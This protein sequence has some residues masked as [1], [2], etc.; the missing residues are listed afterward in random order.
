MVWFKDSFSVCPP[1]FPSLNPSLPSIFPSTKTCGL[2]ALYSPSF[3][4]TILLLA[5]YQY[6]NQGPERL[7]K[8][9]TV[10]VWEGAWPGSAWSRSTHSFHHT[11]PRTG[12]PK[13]TCLFSPGIPG[14]CPMGAWSYIISAEVE[15]RLQEERGQSSLETRRQQK[16]QRCRSGLL[17]DREPRWQW[18]SLTLINHTVRNEPLNHLCTS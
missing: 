2:D 1:A 3:N 12:W 7:K 9:L 17:A 16:P 13:T 4:L 15:Q 6:G 18:I 11:A 8:P 5:F 10:L 14:T